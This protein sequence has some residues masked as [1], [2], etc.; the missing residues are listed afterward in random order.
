MQK[1]DNGKFVVYV[2]HNKPEY[3]DVQCYDGIFTNFI[4]ESFS[5]LRNCPDS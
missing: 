1:Q 3:G 4:H 2:V 5:Y